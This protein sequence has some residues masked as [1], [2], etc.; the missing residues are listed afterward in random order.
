MLD[1][2]QK[3]AAGS[4]VLDLGARTGSFHTD[5]TDLCIVR[6]DLEIPSGRAAGAYVAADA[7]RMPFAS[8]SFDLVVSNHS[9]EH[10][11]ELEA[12]VREIG[13]VIRRD[14]VL[15]IAVP[16]AGTF[17]DR[18][19]RWM[20]RGGGHVNAFRSP[21]DVTRLVERLTGLRTRSTRVLYSSLAFLNSHNLTRRPQIKSVL[22]AFGNE[23]FLA[24][25]MWA[26]R[27]IDRS[28]YT[29]LSQYGW[30]FYFG[31]VDL[32]G[33]LEGWI[34]VCVRCGSAASV[35][36]LKKTGAIPPIP[37]ALQSYRC[38]KCGAYNLLTGD[39]RGE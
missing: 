7:A 13:R 37:R 32:P 2:V 39:S 30:A 36:F 12:T 6:L 34:N 22:F 10:F 14:G 28:L 24:I 16:D 23:R 31:E 35:A 21:G 17:S 18:I 25:L 3:L 20:G 29:R 27:W 33:N 5:R 38:P 26:L 11:P 8:G 1:L 4:R 9:L 15:Y 19:Y